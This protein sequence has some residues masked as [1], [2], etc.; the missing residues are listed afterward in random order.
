MFFLRAHPLIGLTFA[1]SLAVSYLCIKLVQRAYV[2]RVRFIAIVLAL[3][4]IVTCARMLAQ[5][6][7][8]VHTR[9]PAIA[10]LIIVA[11]YLFA[12]LLLLKH[13]RDVLGP[14]AALRLAEATAEQQGVETRPPATA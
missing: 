9:V 3:C 13:N 12:I 8:L 5:E 10:D 6:N 11:L 14:Y 2:S 7:A 4:G 1:L